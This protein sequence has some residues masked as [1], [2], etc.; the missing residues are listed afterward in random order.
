MLIKINDAVPDTP[1]EQFQFAYLLSIELHKANEENQK[2]RALQQQSEVEIDCLKEEVARLK[3]QLQLAQLRQ[4][5][6]RTETNNPP[7]EPE[8]R[9]I[10]VCAHTRK[11]GKKSCGRLIDTSQM[12][13]H[14]VHH[15]LAERDKIC[16]GCHQSLHFLEKEST[17]Q[18]EVLP[19]RL[20][21]VEHIRYKYGC[22]TCDTLKMG[23]KTL[24]PIP[25]ALAGASLLTEVLVNKYQYHLPL[26][27]P[28]KILSSFN[29]SIPD[30]TLGNWVMKLGDGLMKLYEALWQE[31]LSA[32]YLPL[33]ET[34]VKVL[35]PDKKGYLWSYYAPYIGSGVVVFDMSL[36]RKGEVAEKRLKDFKGLLQ[37]DAYAGYQ[38]LRNQEAIE[39]LGCLTHARRKFS[40]VF[41][42]NKAPQGIA[43]QALERLK[44]L[45]A[46]ERGMREKNYHFRTRKRLR[47]KVSWPILKD[48]YQWL[49][50]IAKTIPP[51]SQLGN[52]IS[53]TVNQWSYLIKYLRHGMAEIDTNCV[54]NLIR[55]IAL[56]RKNW[57]FMQPQDSGRIHALFYSL[58]LTCVLNKVNPRLYLHYRLTKMHDLRMGTI[59]PKDYLPHTIH[60][61]LLQTFSNEQIALAKQV[62]N[63]S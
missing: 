4:F 43:A 31:I 60:Q 46:L 19:L 50:K 53:Y 30:N 44:P 28:S 35:K 23:A 7:V 42:I 36:T 40:E 47:Q 54:E 51:K 12:L 61:D 57:L 27:R 20:Y 62:L 6:K 9:Q 11:G 26:Y 10:S 2:L 59:N 8:A 32:A 14:V 15:D 33:D 29:A 45:Y 25:K 24:S 34:P 18:V 48:F 5:G 41:K 21:V 16:N 17:E 13:R 22:R 38:G 58:V 1:L 55:D 63:S 39:G 52:A 3:E 49:K 37:T 56:G